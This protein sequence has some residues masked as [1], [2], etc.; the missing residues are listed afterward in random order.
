L[1]AGK[2]GIGPITKFDAREFSSQIAG[3]IK[4]FDPE[5]Y[6]ERKEVKKMD[7]F[8]HYAIAASEMAVKHAQLPETG[9]DKTRV[10]V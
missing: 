8:I 4:E 5:N 2:S 7:T 1:C 9:V 10:G 3:E 6:I